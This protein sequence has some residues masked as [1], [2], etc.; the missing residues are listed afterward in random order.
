[1]W[2]QG[3]RPSGPRRSLRQRRPR[4]SRGATWAEVAGLR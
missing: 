4:L 1:M 3:Q 2:T